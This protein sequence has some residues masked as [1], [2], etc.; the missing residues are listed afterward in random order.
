VPQPIVIFD[1]TVSPT[2]SNNSCTS[3]EWDLTQFR[4]V[5]LHLPETAGGCLMQVGL[6][7]SAAGFIDMSS[8]LGTCGTTES[9]IASIDPQLGHTLR[10]QW[11]AASGHWP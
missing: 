2:A 5:V 3:P 7:H 9:R 6:N 8:A 11:P 1:E 10:L 4:R